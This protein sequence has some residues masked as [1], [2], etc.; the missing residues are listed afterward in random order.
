[1]KVARVIPL[2][3]EGSKS[4]V[5]NY[6]PISLLNSFSKIYEKLMHS[7]I[8]Q[9]LESNNSIYE[10]QYGFRPGRCCEHALLNAQNCLLDSLSKRKISLLLFIDFSKAFDMVDH[11]ILLKKLEHYGIRGIT[12]NWLKSYLNNRKQFVSVN[13]ADSDTLEMKYGV[14]QGSILG[15]LLFLIYINDIPE[16]AKFANF[17]LYA[18][19][20]NIII[21]AQTIEEIHDQLIGLINSLVKWVNANGLALN[22]KKTNYMIFSR[23]KVDLPKPLI[24]SHTLI[25][26][27]TEARFLGVIIDESLNWSRH[28]KTILSKMCK[29]IGVMF[30]IKKFLPLKARLQVYHSFIQSHISYCSMVWGFCCKSNIE[31]IFSKQKVGMRAVI[32]GYINYKYKDGEI[33]G[34]T[35]PAFTEYKI[36]TVHNL[37]SLSSLLFILKIRK[38]PNVLPTSVTCTISEESPKIS[39][40]VETCRNWLEIYNTDTYRNSIF[41]KGPLL[42]IDPI[43]NEILHET[44]NLP[45]FNTDPTLD[46]IPH[47]TSNLSNV[48]TDPTL[49]EIPHETSNLSNYIEPTFNEIVHETSNLSKVSSPSLKSYKIDL[50]NILLDNQGHGSLSEWEYKNF[51][52]YNIAGLRKSQRN[53]EV[54]DYA[55]NEVDDYTVSWP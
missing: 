39:S 36:L 16:I 55:N 17:I 37:I 27:K 43:L 51:L 1:M 28:V 13:G 9:F 52:I 4:D 21:T 41:F 2:H 46:E 3:K 34:H 8:L 44:S 22:L 23:S 25:E 40:N 18:D 5:S 7:R 15:P 19:D 6:R 50:K 53:N 35:K 48:N 29:Y 38:F 42:Y 45:N 10:N 26:R 31:S 11:S 30:K 24:I 54:V 47:E 14:P 20:A 32:P 33:P 12:L 49:N